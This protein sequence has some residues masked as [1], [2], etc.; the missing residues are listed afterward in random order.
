MTF[1]KECILTLIGCLAIS[2][3]CVSLCYFRWQESKEQVA[4]LQI[5]N[6]ILRGNI[7]G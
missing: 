6:K 7:D 3:F 2:A 4:I 5:E 1:E